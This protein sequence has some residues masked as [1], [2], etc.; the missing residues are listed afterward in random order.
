MRVVVDDR[1]RDLTKLTC[2]PC[3]TRHR[4]PD[5]GTRIAHVL[6]ERSEPSCMTTRCGSGLLIRNGVYWYLPPTKVPFGA[7][8]TS[9]MN[10]WFDVIT[11]R[12]SSLVRFTA[13][14]LLMKL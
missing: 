5:Q 10:R 4:T 7:I 14:F 13:Y 8:F 11:R 3:S 1:G 6:A 12:S 9:N 2:L